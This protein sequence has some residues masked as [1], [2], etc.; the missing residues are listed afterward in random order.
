MPIARGRA[1]LHQIKRCSAPCTGVIDLAAY[2]ALVDHAQA[3]LK[4]RSRVVI[5]DFIATDDASIRPA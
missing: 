5:D 1:C 2:Q 3:F 4:G